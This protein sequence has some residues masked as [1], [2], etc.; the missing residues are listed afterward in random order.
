MKNQCGNV[1]KSTRNISHKPTKVLVKFTLRKVHFGMRLHKVLEYVLFLLF[2]RGWQTLLLLSLIV[3]HFLDHGP[4]F[5]VQIGQLGVLR[6][7]FFG[8]Y[9]GVL[10]D[11][12]APP[13]HLVN[14]FNVNQ[15]KLAVVQRPRGLVHLDVMLKIIVN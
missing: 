1:E 7:H 6:A 3:H 10:G 2:V 15:N 13:F 9:F 8:V 12:L 11:Q 4:G 5:T 14:L